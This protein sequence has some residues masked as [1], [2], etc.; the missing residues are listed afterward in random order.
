M[1]KSYSVHNVHNVSVS[2]DGIS[3]DFVVF[4]GEHI[5]NVMAASG[6]FYEYDLLRAIR[7]LGRKGVYIDVGAFIGTHT[8]WFAKAC[9]AWHVLA[10]EPLDR[11]IQL[12]IANTS[13]L[14]G[15]TCYQHAVSDS[16]GKVE[17]RV[18]RKQKPVAT[19]EAY[20]LD[21][22]VDPS[23]LSRV[24]FI[25]VDVEGHE[26]AV[27]RGASQIIELSRPCLSVEADDKEEQQLLFSW[28]KD[29]KYRNAGQYCKTPTFLLVPDEL[30]HA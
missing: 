29:H 25:K 8:V 6:K 22:V 30:P 24:A 21:H 15:V 9:Q 12:L 11:P 20:M 19:S 18:L 23:F 26:L 2:L 16:D 1:K 10:F 3:A 4:D 17:V 14:A 13:G 5:G 27:L 28:A 7:K